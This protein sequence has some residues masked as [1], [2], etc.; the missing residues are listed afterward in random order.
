[1]GLTKGY[2]FTGG[3]QSGMLHE[4]N[5]SRPAQQDWSS[6]SFVAREGKIVFVDG[7]CSVNKRSDLLNVSEKRRNKLIEILDVVERAEERL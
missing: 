4:C 5:H 7:H 3:G 1:M 2:G 6:I